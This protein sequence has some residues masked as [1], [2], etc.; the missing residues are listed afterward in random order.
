M[1]NRRQPRFSRIAA[2][3]VAVALHGTIICYW[4]TRRMERPGTSLPRQPP[5]EVTFFSLPRQTGAQLSPTRE[6]REKTP[7]TARTRKERP[8]RER[9]I[10]EGTTQPDT[11]KDV[12]HSKVDWNR[13]LMREVPIIASCLAEKSRRN[14]F[15]SP[16][17]AEPVPAAPR[18]EWDGWDYAATHRIERLPQGGIAINL[19]DRCAIVFIPF[20]L[21]GCQLGRIEANNSDMFKDLRTYRDDEPNA[22]P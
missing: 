4:L 1:W 20:P 15:I 3:A 22:L 14:S 13:E 18:H 10:V 7:R 6:L 2:A 8:V 11:R 5:L 12:P 16:M 19:N 9:M 21:I 17:P